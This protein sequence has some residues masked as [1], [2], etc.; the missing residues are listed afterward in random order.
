M[1]NKIL[2]K[3]K[4]YRMAA[5][6]EIELLKEVPKLVAPTGDY[7]VIQNAKSID[8]EI[9]YVSMHGDLHKVWL[10]VIS[11]GDVKFS[12]PTYF[13]QKRHDSAL[14]PMVEGA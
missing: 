6:T 4:G 5:I 10:E 3:H 9:L 14:F 12:Q 7:A 1:A 8:T 13:M 11:G 2:L